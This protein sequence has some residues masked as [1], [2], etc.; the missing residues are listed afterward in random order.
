[1]VRQPF[2]SLRFSLK[3]KNTRVDNAQLYETKTTRI[4]Y[5]IF[6]NMTLRVTTSKVIKLP[7]E[8]FIKFWSEEYCL[9]GEYELQVIRKTLIA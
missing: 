6:S 8:T 2:F 9:F 3:R 1:M 5:L 4:F 7:G